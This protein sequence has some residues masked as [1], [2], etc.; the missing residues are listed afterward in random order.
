MTK[1]LQRLKKYRHLLQVLIDSTPKL[2]R[3]I[4]SHCEGEFIKVLLEIILN[5][6]DVNVEIK[7]P[8]KE[9][10]RKH[11]QTLRNL[12]ASKRVPG[13][14]KI[15]KQKGGAFLPLIISAVLSSAIGKL[16]NS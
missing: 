13:K 7:K 11:K 3:S 4:L 2:K 8:C 1:K 14:R 15:L 10:L 6:L 5:T 12:I 9:K 16:I